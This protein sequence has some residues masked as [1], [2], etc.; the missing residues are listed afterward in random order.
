MKIYKIFSFAIFLPFIFGC[1]SSHKVIVL[2]SDTEDP[3][4]NAFV[5]TCEGNMLNP[6]NYS[7]LYKTDKD[8]QVYI[9]ES[10]DALLIVAGKFEYSMETDYKYR[11]EHNDHLTVSKI[12]LHVRNNE[13]KNKIPLLWIRNNMLREIQNGSC[14]YFL[15]FKRYCDEIEEK[16]KSSNNTDVN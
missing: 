13:T 8:G 7:A 10:G 6:F 4:E 16:I 3:I 14:R 5:F 9:N 1:A 12:Y 2:D 11:K 15:E